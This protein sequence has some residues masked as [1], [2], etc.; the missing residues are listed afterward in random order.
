[1]VYR[2]NKG[3]RLTIRNVNSTVTPIEINLLSGFRLT[4]RNVNT[5]T[6]SIS[7]CFRKSF[8]LTIR[9]VNLIIFLLLLQLI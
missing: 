3:F 7:Y 5:N 2:F 6:A 4:I 8:R 9:N 1:M